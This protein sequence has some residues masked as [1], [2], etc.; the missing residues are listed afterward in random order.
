[1]A[2]KVI[3]QWEQR[4]AL[5]KYIYACLVGEIDEESIVTEAHQKSNFDADQMKVLEYWVANNKTIL[6]IL[7]KHLNKTWTWKRLSYIDQALLIEAYSESKTLETP[8]AV[9]IDQTIITARKYS[10]DETYKFINAILDK[11]L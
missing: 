3:P 6:V 5:F 2:E 7:G 8:K 9:L 10:N 1:M 4:V 11:V